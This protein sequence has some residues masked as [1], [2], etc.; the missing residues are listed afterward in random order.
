MP[1]TS[2]NL[3]RY[4]RHSESWIVR[5]Q[6]R[7]WLI[8]QAG[9]Y[10]PDHSGCQA[11]IPVSCTKPLLCSAIH[12]ADERFSFRSSGPHYLYVGDAA[13]LHRSAPLAHRPVSPAIVKTALRHLGERNLAGSVCAVAA[14][15]TA[16]ILPPGVATEWTDRRHLRVMTRSL[17]GIFAYWPAIL[18]DV[19]VSVRGSYRIAAGMMTL[20]DTRSGREWIAPGAPPHSPLSTEAVTRTIPLAGQDKLRRRQLH[21][22]WRHPA[23][24]PLSE[25]DSALPGLPSDIGPGC[26]LAEVAA[27]ATRRL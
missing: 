15:H 14:H 25:R 18:S 4:P 13:E 17:Y 9:A 7:K 3:L 23:S 11:A 16:R 24:G 26:G 21:D 27:L 5:D 2:R 12:I 1:R 8:G 20:L 6:S 22:A 10:R 19:S